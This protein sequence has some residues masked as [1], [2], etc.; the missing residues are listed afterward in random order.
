MT[1]QHAAC[2]VIDGQELQ[3]QLVGHL[4]YD[5]LP[6]RSKVFDGCSPKPRRSSKDSETFD[7]VEHPKQQE[8]PEHEAPPPETHPKTRME[9]PVHRCCSFDRSP[10]ANVSSQLT[11]HAYE[12]NASSLIQAQLDS[13]L[14]SPDGNRAV[15]QM[16]EWGERFGSAAGHRPPPA[17]PLPP[18]M[19]APPPSNLL[20]AQTPRAGA[21]NP[22]ATLQSDFSVPTC[23]SKEAQLVQAW[24]DSLF[25]N[26]DDSDAE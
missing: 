4:Q 21:G 10:E 13:L 22:E 25:A 18:G 12:S 17:P 26:P 2:A 16:Q 14:A 8:L 1:S 24:V 6:P 9:T 11:L 20:V 19:Q 7:S 23:D 5:E 3:S 15:S